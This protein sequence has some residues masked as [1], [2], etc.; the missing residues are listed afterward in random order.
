ME[1]PISEYYLKLK[2]V[3][4]DI[5]VTD[6]AG[7]DLKFEPGLKEAVTLITS[8]AKAGGKLMF[9]GNGASAS[10]ASHMAT[11][12]WRN[13]RIKAIAFND[14][15]LLTCVANDF[16]YDKVFAK[17]IEMF[18]DSGDILV[19]IS[20]SGRS[21]NIVKGVRMALSRGCRVISLSGFDRDN[22]LRSL[23]EIN[24]YAPSPS[25]GQVE[26][27]HHSICHCI[28]DA[29]VSGLGKK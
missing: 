24:F 14:G 12:F 22:E 15:A 11:D 16:G 18:A 23:G 5:S 27:V 9:I 4:Q 17:P 10:I 25:Y 29:I 2:Q 13:G 21:E 3:I 20:S 26:V 8:C 1:K 19:A 7:K 6:Q 28:L